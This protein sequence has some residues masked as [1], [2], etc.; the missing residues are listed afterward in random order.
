MRTRWISGGILSRLTIGALPYPLMPRMSE[1]ANNPRRAVQERR[2][3][4]AARSTEKSEGPG[5]YGI[6][7][8]SEPPG[9]LI[10]FRSWRVDYDETGAP[11]L[12]S[13]F[14]PVTWSEAVH[15]A[16]C[17]RDLPTP[18]RS[19]TPAHQ[20]PHDAPHPACG[21]GIFVAG[22]PDLDFPT[23]DHQGV[24]GL[25]ACFGR[26]V[27]D[28]RGTRVA[29]VRVEALGTYEHWSRRQHRAV[30]ELSSRLEIDL[31]DLRLLEA[32]ALDYGRPAT[33]AFA[34]A[35]L[36]SQSLADSS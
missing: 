30:R 23:L 18:F 7:H 6:G 24:T 13:R 16:D 21:C 10:G 34:A 29:R 15:V 36:T 22:R 2:A 1:S 4:G 27:Q 14:L 20:A 11:E 17:Y 26:V 3:A 35:D 32:A 8:G 19:S 9:P 12:R 5:D 25:V 33:K 28:A 31:V